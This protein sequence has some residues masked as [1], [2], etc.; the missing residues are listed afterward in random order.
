[1][2]PLLRCALW[3]LGL[4]AVTLSGCKND[5]DAPINTPAPASLRLVGTWQHQSASFSLLIC[6][7]DSLVAYP[8]DACVA[9]NLFT[10]GADSLY[11]VNEGPTRCNA[12]T[13]QTQTGDWRLIENN[14]RLLTRQDVTQPYDTARV[15][16]FTDSTIYLEQ[17]YNCPAPNYRFRLRR[18]Q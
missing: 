12:A 1:M 18:V 6:N 16:A 14:T 10:F 8:L 3:C 5:D 13:P 7:S 11:T 4:C 9:D 2:N 17:A 15:I